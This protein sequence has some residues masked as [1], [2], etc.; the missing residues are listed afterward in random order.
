[1]N[2]VDD[3]FKNKLEQNGLEFQE[4]YWKDMEDLI[5]QENKKKKRF[6]L[7]FATLFVLLTASIMGL[8]F[9]KSSAGTKQQSKVNSKPEIQ[10]VNEAKIT[11]GLNKENPATLNEISQTHTKNS[12]Q[13]QTNRTHQNKPRR[14]NSKNIE[15]QLTSPFSSN[16]INE[17]IWS[18]ATET[19]DKTNLIFT[20]FLRF[21][22]SEVE[23]ERIHPATF[24]RSKKNFPL[25]IEK[26]MVNWV[27]QIGFQVLDNINDKTAIKSNLENSK[28]SMGYL[29][30]FSSY[31]KHW[32]FKTGLEYYQY[33]EQNKYQ[34]DN[35]TYQFDTSYNLINAFYA[36]TPKGTRIALI[37]RSIDT[38]EF[39]NTNFIHTKL[40]L[41]YINIP[42]HGFYTFKQ[43]KLNFQLAAGLNTGLL[44]RKTGNY[45]NLVQ[46]KYEPIEAAQSNEF[47]TLMIQSYL[48]LS[49]SYPIY[50]QFSLQSSFGLQYGLS[51]FRT[52]SYS[53]LNR[54]NLGLGLVYSLN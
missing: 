24:S 1:M 40:G 29:A 5:E 51:R 37:Q 21:K 32:G 26:P 35:K 20:E 14:E 13:A 39:Q 50:K 6:I 4:A 49:L 19:D 46:G 42:L 44:I 9:N 22:T 53:K 12:L 11:I 25:K 45:S 38:T 54:M 7:F 15:N 36:L 23:L 34:N 16:D 8:L 43:G 33:V 3:L 2:K 47:K 41:Q 10:S 17:N 31:K 27:Y 48:G 30:T 18:L 52:S 28:N